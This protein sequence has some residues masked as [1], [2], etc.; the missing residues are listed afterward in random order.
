MITI[1]TDILKRFK[2]L[3]I[4]LFPFIIVRKKT[5]DII[6]NHEKIHIQQQ[7]E[8]GVI[9]F[10]IIYLIWHLK[11]GYINNPFEVEAFNNQLNKNY[12]KTRKRWGYFKNKNNI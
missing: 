9:P 10:Y 8:L 4:A 3:G 12:L 1:K 5:D 2:I 11:Y 6:I 7:L